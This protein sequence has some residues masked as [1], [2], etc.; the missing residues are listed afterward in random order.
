MLLDCS[1]HGSLGLDSGDEVLVV[2][3]AGR[4]LIAS[5]GVQLD[6]VKA[7]VYLRYHAL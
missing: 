7:H 1:V 4:E 3:T 6:S 2:L 5:L